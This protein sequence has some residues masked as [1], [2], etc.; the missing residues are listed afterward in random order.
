MHKLII[1]E[2]NRPILIRLIQISSP[3]HYALWN[4]LS[5]ETLAGDLRGE[6]K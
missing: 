3:D 6:F 1:R 2:K 4:A 5:S